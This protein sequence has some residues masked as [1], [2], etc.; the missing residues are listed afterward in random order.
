MAPLGVRGVTRDARPRHTVRI[1][2]RRIPSRTAGLSLA[3]VA[4][5]AVFSFVA[6][7]W[8]RSDSI[9]QL[10]PPP[11]SFTDVE[12]DWRCSAGHTFAATGQTGTRGC[13]QCGGAASPYAI[14]ACEKHKAFE[15]QAE[16]AGDKEGRTGV[17]KFKAPG[18][19]WTDA[20]DGPKCP[21]CGKVMV[22]KQDPLAGL[23]RGKRKSGG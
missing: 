7:R 8:W 15:V 2:K 13:P 14:Y 5:T 9:T 23:I 10:A 19:E 18:G 6:W 21:R 12:M 16:F 11:T 17:A 4:F 22:R 1:V 20:A 3:A